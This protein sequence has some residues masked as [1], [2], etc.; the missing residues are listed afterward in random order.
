M[1]KYDVCVI[2]GGWAG[3]NAALLASKR[4]KSVCLV[5]KDAL[6]GTCLN[7]GC[8][9]TK[10]FITQS[11]NGLSFPA[12]QEKRLAAVARLGK[13]VESLLR[14]AKVTVVRGRGRDIG[15]HSIAVEGG[16]SIDAG[17]VIIATGSRP[18]ALPQLPLDG[19]KL[20]SS[21]DFFSLSEL[22]GNWLVVGGGVIGCEFACFLRRMGCSV[23]VCELLPR[24][25]AGFE[26]DVSR[27][28]QQEMAKSGITVLVG[29]KVEELDLGAYDKVLLAVGREPVL[30]GLWA[31]TAALGTEK[32]FISADRQGRTT[33][34]SIYAAG[35]CIGGYLL[36]HVA[37]YEG[38]LAAA[39][40]CG[41]A[42]KRDYA[43]VPASVFT[44][45]EAGAVG[46]TEAEARTFGAAC[47]ARTVHFLS[48]GMAHVREE[49]AGFVKVIAEEGSGRVLGAHIIG[50]EASELVNIFSLIVKNKM[51][52]KDIRHTIFA[53]PSISEVIGEIARAF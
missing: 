10:V 14:Q 27:R 17:A 45:P 46:L 42:E 13:G 2:G 23:T 39:N 31:D 28:L 53:H 49:T 6:G 16:E 19:K 43:A 5:E 41:D 29:Q 20:I 18:R 3:L 11:K 52:V 7:R 48:V 9:P 37:A 15:P 34:P 50:P 40:A 32:G 8:I 30:D 24:L 51:T 21:D 12:M 26:A 44:A 4:G 1:I 22:P 38:E 36:A 47:Q 35:D 33:V 25:L